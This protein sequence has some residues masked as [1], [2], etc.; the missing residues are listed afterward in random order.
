MSRP[1]NT[2]SSWWQ[3]RKHYFTFGSILQTGTNDDLPAD[4]NNLKLKCNPDASK[5]IQGR[6][7][8]NFPGFIW[9]LFLLFTWLWVVTADHPIGMICHITNLDRPFYNILLTCRRIDGRWEGAEKYYKVEL[10]QEVVKVAPPPTEILLWRSS[11]LWQGIQYHTHTHTPN[12]RRLYFFFTQTTISICTCVL[13]KYV[14]VCFFIFHPSSV[15][16]WEAPR[17]PT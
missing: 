4:I 5:A 3:P 9:W 10:A 6:G 12:K 1:Q 7:I 17:P 8:T 16:L 13:I 2:R 14:F 11:N 15:S